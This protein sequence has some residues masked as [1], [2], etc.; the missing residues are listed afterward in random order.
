MDVLQQAAQRLRYSMWALCQEAGVSRTLPS[1]EQLV[2]ALRKRQQ[3]AVMEEACECAHCKRQ[4][5]TK[6]QCAASGGCA[7]DSKFTEGTEKDSAGRTICWDDQTGKRI[8]CGGGGQPTAPSG[9]NRKKGKKAR[10]RARARAIAARQKQSQAEKKADAERVARGQSAS[11]AKKTVFQKGRELFAKAKKLGLKGMAKATGKIAKEQFDKLRTELPEAAHAQMEQYVHNSILGKAI[12]AHDPL[13]SSGVPVS[14][15]V[16]S[17][18]AA[19]AAVKAY[20]LVKKLKTLS[21]DDA[22][23]MMLK[24]G[25]PSVDA[26]TGSLGK[27]IAG[28]S[29]QEAGEK[30]KTGIFRDKSGHRYKLV[31]G[32]RTALSKG[33]QQQLAAAQR[34]MQ[35]AS[36]QQASMNARLAASQ[37]GTGMGQPAAPPPKEETPAQPQQKPQPQKKPAPK[38]KQAAPAQGEQAPKE[39]GKAATASASIAQK[40]KAAAAAVSKAKATVASLG[41]K[42]RAKIEAKAATAKS[43]TVRGVLTAVLNAPG[44]A[45]NAVAAL[46]QNWATGHTGSAE[47]FGQQTAGVDVGVG[48]PINAATVAKAGTTLAAHG[49]I[50]GVKLAKKLI[51][52]RKAKKEAQAAGAASAPE[53]V[54]AFV[55]GEAQMSPAGAEQLGKDIA[56]AAKKNPKVLDDVVRQLNL[57]P[58]AHTKPKAKIKA[59]TADLVKRAVRARAMESIEAIESQG[60]T[61]S[62]RVLASKV[63][64]MLRSLDVGEVPAPDQIA[65][66]IMAGM[67]TQTLAEALMEAGFSG[68]KEITLKSGKKRRMCFADGKVVPC[69]KIAR[70]KAVRQAS[71]KV[72]DKP[73]PKETQPM[74]PPKFVSHTGAI[75]WQDTL[76]PPEPFTGDEAAVFDT[77]RMAYQQLR[78]KS[79]PVKVPDL[80]DEIRKDHPEVSILQAHQ[81][82]VK[83]MKHD[84]ALVLQIVNDPHVEARSAEMVTGL[85]RGLHGYLQWRD[86][87]KPLPSQPK[88]TKAKTPR[89]EEKPATPPVIPTRPPR[90]GNVAE[91]AAAIKG[92]GD[93]LIAD[94]RRDSSAKNLAKH[95]KRVDDYFSKL[96]MDI[97]TPTGAASI[98]TALGYKSLS[99]NAAHVYGALAAKIK[100]RM[101]MFV[102][103]SL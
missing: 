50:Q 48:G 37:K 78:R 73:K 20:M 96:M 43:A 68:M 44:W 84:D 4:G 55:K 76:P 46:V 85:P 65:H 18:V 40:A 27:L 93:S 66:E 98:A 21:T 51:T 90:N 53:R 95:E 56:H 59:I 54:A 62:V 29:L 17:A 7:A 97:D 77:A 80:V 89:Q 103:S 88:A 47:T 25:K 99:G 75:A 38:D 15:R 79:I 11:P 2:L 12:A 34:A 28:E 91:H 102:R 30:G 13:T 72:E 42:A 86:P 1:E 14:T 60:K 57:D 24:F 8:P 83:W 94:L 74:T 61:W 39:K 22:R 71:H 69:P 3:R 23:E 67:Q 35:A 19:V 49:V 64:R 58:A 32:K 36:A 87:S 41:E 82:L 101:G 63:A 81:L 33:E 100:E 5:L 45:A 10:A 52:K 31:K 70:K 6:A 26:A 92:L 9:G 16:L